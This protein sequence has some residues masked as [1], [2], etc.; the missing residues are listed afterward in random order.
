MA[1]VMSLIMTSF[2]IRR[3]NRTIISKVEDRV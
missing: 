1:E 2:F 3:I